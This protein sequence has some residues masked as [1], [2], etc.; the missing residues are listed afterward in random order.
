MHG[1]HFR[2]AVRWQVVATVSLLSFITIIDR[3]RIASAKADIAADLGITD[4]QFGWVFGAF[5]LG[6]AILMIPSGWW[7]DHVGPRVFLTAIVCCW[8]LLTVST[9]FATALVPLV[10]IRFV[11]GLAE[12]GAYPTASR[13]LY[14]WVP[15]AE[16]GLALGLMNAGSRFGA[17]TGL[18]IASFTIL[19]VGWRTCFWLLGT[20]GVAWAGWWYQWY[21]NDPAQKQGISSDKLDYIRSVTRT[22]KTTPDTGS[23]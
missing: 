8:S 6:Y 11:F 9:G 4:V 1:H 16:R 5:T 3:V 10:A 13:A 22:E 2:T 20:V 23:H 18:A 21:R 19:L 14:R 17:A 12:A 7:G 15:P